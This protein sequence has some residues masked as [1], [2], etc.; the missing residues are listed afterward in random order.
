MCSQAYQLDLS[1]SI[2]IPNVLMHFIP[3]T[4]HMP[5]TW[6]HDGPM[7]YTISACPNHPRPHA[8]CDDNLEHSPKA[9]TSLSLC[10][11]ARSQ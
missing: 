11:Q 10:G 9:R 8:Q 7:M 4:G 2:F 3:E 6:M 5:L 1:I